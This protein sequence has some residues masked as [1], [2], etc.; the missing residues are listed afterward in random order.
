MTMAFVTYAQN[1]GQFQDCAKVVLRV[2]PN[3]GKMLQTTETI[4]RVAYPCQKGTC[5]ANTCRLERFVFP[6]HRIPLSPH[7][8][9]DCR[10]SIAQAEDRFTV[11]CLFAFLAGSIV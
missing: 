4:Q 10:C 11:L 1:E 7:H 5:D 9:A 6:P 8:S 2:Q 3:N